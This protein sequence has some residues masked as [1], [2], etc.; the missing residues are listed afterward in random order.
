MKRVQKED[1]VKELGDSFGENDNFYLVDFKGISVS[2]SVELRKLMRENSYSFRVI[3]NRLAVKALKEDFPESLIELFQ[4]PTAIA[5]APQDPLGLAKMLTDF[6]TK[7]KILAVKGG[8]FEG[9][10]ISSEMFK[11]VSRIESRE[12]LLGKIG[13]LMAFPLMKLFRT[14][15]APLVNLSGLL[16]QL[17]TK[18]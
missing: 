5:F 9:Q 2:Q 3:K 13:F 17:K 10:F 16:S 4:G 6:S 7:T 14:W 11:E 8:I 18:K 15:Q 12:E 1:I